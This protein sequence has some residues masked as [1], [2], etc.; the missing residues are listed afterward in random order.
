MPPFMRPEL[1]PK[2]H[3]VVI[4]GIVCQA[5]YR[6]DIDNSDYPA[7]GLENLAVAEDRHFW[8]TSRRQLICDTFEKYIAPQSHI[9]EVGAGTGY[10]ANGLQIRGYNLTVCE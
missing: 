8:F 9:I 2:T 5:L 4:D 6:A 7:Q 10:V 3:P 1:Q